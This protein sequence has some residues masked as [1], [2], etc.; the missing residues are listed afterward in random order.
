MNSNSA[1]LFNFAVGVFGFVTTVASVALFCRSYLPGAQMKI[2]DELLKETRTIFEIAD[3]DGL[4][5]SDAFRKTSLTMLIWYVCLEFAF[6][7][8]SNILTADVYDSS[9]ESSAL[10]RE[11]TYNATTTIQEYLALFKGLTQSIM[12][13]SDRVKNLRSCLIVRIF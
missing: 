13:L 11:R 5:P 9:E 6:I 8:S 4:F 1:N 2:L 12:Q 10:L 7:P 3:A